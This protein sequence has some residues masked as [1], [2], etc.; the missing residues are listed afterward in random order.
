MVALSRLCHWCR[1]VGTASEGNRLID[2]LLIGVTG[3]RHSRFGIVRRCLI[4]RREVVI[5]DMHDAGASSRIPSGIGDAM[6]NN[7]RLVVVAFLTYC[8]LVT[9]TVLKNHRIPPPPPHP[10][11]NPR[12]YCTSRI[13]SS[14]CT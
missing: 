9:A 6:L 7:E 4:H 3:L 13:P 8:G 1:P 11:P 14:A 10:P 12:P 5:A 2:I